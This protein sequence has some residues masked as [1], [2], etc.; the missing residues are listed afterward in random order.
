MATLIPEHPVEDR[1]YR[2]GAGGPIKPFRF[3]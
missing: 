3:Q 1:V 2:A